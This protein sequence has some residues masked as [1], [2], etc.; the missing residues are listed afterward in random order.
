MQ[1]ID[2]PF[3]HFSFKLHN[4]EHATMF[5]HLIVFAAFMLCAELIHSFHTLSARTKLEISFIA[6]V[7]CQE[8]FLPHFHSADHVGLEGHY[9]WLLQLIV[10]ASVMAA[11]AAT[12][13]RTNLPAALVLSISVVFQGCWFINMGFMLW[14]FSWILCGI[15]IFTGC[16]CLK[17]VGK[18]IPRELSIEYEQLQSRGA[19]VPIAINDF[20]E[21]HP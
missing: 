4:L 9:H 12:C 8:L 21:A 6:S 20:K 5:L 14:Q 13:F 15:L 1:V 2:F 18:C 3:L 11:V 10:F 19:D 17:F 7:F 16:T